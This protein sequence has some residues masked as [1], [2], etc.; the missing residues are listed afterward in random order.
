MEKAQQ[1]LADCVLAESWAFTAAGCALAI[2][3]GVMRKSLNPLVYCGMTGTLA[4]LFH[5]YWQCSK[6]RETVAAMQEVAEGG[7]KVVATR[8][9]TGFSGGGRKD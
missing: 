5:G 2:P 7:D 6:Q 9:L 4:D 8:I 3:I 1:E